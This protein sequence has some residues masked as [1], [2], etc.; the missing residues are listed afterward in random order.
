MYSSLDNWT[1]EF[2][3]INRKKKKEEKRNNKKEKKG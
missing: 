3:R 1:K 2:K